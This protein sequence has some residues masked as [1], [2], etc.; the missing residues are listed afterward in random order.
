MPLCYMLVLLQGS[1]AVGL[2]GHEA[3]VDDWFFPPNIFK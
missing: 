3:L 2:T 1:A